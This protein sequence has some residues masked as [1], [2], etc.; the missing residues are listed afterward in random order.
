LAY[1]RQWLRRWTSDYKSNTTDRDLN[2][3][4]LF[5]KPT[6]GLVFQ[7]LFRYISGSDFASLY[8]FSVE[9]CNCSDSVLFIFLWFYFSIW[10]LHLDYQI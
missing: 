5:Q 10:Q 7:W 1:D 4:Q 6:Q 9:F 2:P 3:L 8:Y